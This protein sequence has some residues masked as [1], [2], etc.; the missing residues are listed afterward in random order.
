VTVAARSLDQVEAVAAEIGG[1][2]VAL[3]V[4]DP[5]AVERA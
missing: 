5:A 4:A 2:P 3:D 1:T